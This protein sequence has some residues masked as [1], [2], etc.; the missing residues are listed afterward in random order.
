VYRSW[1]SGGNTV[2]SSHWRVVHY[3]LCNSVECTVCYQYVAKYIQN[4]SFISPALLARGIFLPHITT[5]TSFKRTHVCWI[6]RGIILTSLREASVDLGSP[7]FK[8][9][10]R[11]EFKDY[12]GY[13]VR[14]LVFSY[15]QKI[16]LAAI[17]IDRQNGLLYYYQTVC[18]TSVKHLKLDCKVGYTIKM[19][20]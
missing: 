7:H 8:Q 15:D 17:C 1:L 10:F 4:K 20:G 18:P 13:E 5:G 16:L 11:I 14:R 3:W 9:P 12:W 19:R 6:C 2:N